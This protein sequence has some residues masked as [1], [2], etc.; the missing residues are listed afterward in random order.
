MK[1]CVALRTGLVSLTYVDCPI[2]GL[3]HMHQRAP[4]QARFVGQ[5]SP[6][7]DPIAY[8]GAV[9]ELLT[10][11]AAHHASTPLIINTCGWIKVACFVLSNPLSL[12]L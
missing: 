4:V 11:H 1:S 12:I 2:Y 10:W 8:R 7:R 9:E 5:L 3:P 6:E